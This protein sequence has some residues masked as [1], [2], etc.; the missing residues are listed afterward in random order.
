MLTD[1][2]NCLR[3]RRRFDGQKK[4]SLDNGCQQ[5]Q[6]PLTVVHGQRG[7]VRCPQ[8]LQDPKLV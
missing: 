6:R 2:N 4:L 5:N 8:K 1:K 3:A 7:R